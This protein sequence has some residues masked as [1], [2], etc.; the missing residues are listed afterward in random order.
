MDIDELQGALLNEIRIL[1]MG[2]NHLLKGQPNSLQLTAAFHTNSTR[3]PPQAVSGPQT[4]KKPTCV[5]CKCPHAF[6]TYEVI[7]DHQKRLDIIKQGKLCFNCLGHHKMSN[8]SSKYQ[9]H[10]CGRK[11]HTSICS[12]S[13][14][15][16]VTLPAQLPTP[17]MQTMRN[18]N[19]A[20]SATFLTVLTHPPSH[21]D[22]T[23]LLKTVI[24][25]ITFSN[26]EAEANILFDKGHNVPS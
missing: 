8:S 17:V 18:T 21:N 1:E 22:K 13:S 9:C 16:N 4:L 11:H 26:V 20:N 3:T 23:C 2:S 14:T 15:D 24:A 10:K 12:G 5:Y 25:A 6:D 7:K 19:T